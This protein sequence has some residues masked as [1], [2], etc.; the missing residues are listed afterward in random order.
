MNPTV[1]D[2][3][4]GLSLG[5]VIGCGLL[6][7]ALFV[8]PGDVFARTAVWTLG[9]FV[10]GVAGLVLLRRSSDATVPAVVTEPVETAAP[11]AGDSE[12]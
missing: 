6:A 4:T 10:L 9:P 2:Q 11:E 5:A 7:L 12:A 8:L 1:R 3:L